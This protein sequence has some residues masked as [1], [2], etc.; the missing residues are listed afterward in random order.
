MIKIESVFEGK[1]LLSDVMEIEKLSYLTE[2]EIL[3]K[4]KE[5]NG[6]FYYE[7]GERTI[8]IFE[9]GYKKN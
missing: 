4:R 2:D 3:S 1:Y 8:N 6:D 9:T 5:P 7:K